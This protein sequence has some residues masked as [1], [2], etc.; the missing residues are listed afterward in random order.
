MPDLRLDPGRA[1][2]HLPSRSLVVADL[3][4]GFEW[5]QRSRG[6]LLPVGRPD[7]TVERIG[8]LARKWDARRVVVLGDVVHGAPTLEGVR[9]ALEGL[10]DAMDGMEW[11][12]VLGNHDRGLAEHLGTMRVHGLS[13]G[14]SWR[15][16]GWVG[17][18]GDK[19]PELR[20]G[21]RVLSGHEHPA[22]HVAK[23]GSGA[24]RLPA[25]A[26]GPMGIILPAFSPWAAGS[27]AGQ[28]P[29]L[30]EWARIHVATT[31]VACIGTRLLPIPAS[32]L[33]R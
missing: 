22:I 21:E 7:D 23:A 4:L 25:F 8:N 17:I 12:I 14:A 18:H 29:P 6:Q 10:F 2:V 20:P 28:R 24:I 31:Y 32:R 13:W 27:L 19:A 1:L 5:V 15:E 26:V 11:T 16:P 3:H 9:R 33:P 30:G